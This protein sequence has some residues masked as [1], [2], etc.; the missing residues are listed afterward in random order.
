MNDEKVKEYW[1]DLLH[2]GNQIQEEDE[3]SLKKNVTGYSISHI[4]S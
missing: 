2:L 4:L 1:N 3:K